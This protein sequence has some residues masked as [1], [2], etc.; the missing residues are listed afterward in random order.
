MKRH[1]LLMVAVLATGRAAAA[2]PGPDPRLDFALNTNA[3]APFERAVEF[4]KT[5]P[6]PARVRKPA[7][8]SP[9]MVRVREDVYVDRQLLPSR[10][11]VRDEAP[12]IR[13]YGRDR[14]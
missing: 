9:R 2:T 12:A 13:V 10:G 5:L 14:R 11:T 7:V 3:I 8:A 1:L 4:W 6:P